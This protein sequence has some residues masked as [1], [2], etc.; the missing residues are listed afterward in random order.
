[1][2]AAAARVRHAPLHLTDG[3]PRECMCG[4]RRMHADVLAVLRQL[5]VREV[6]VVGYSMG[7]SFAL[8]L[9]LVG[10][11]VLPALDDAPPPKCRRLVIAGHGDGLTGWGAEADEVGACAALRRAVPP[12]APSRGSLSLALPWLP[13]A[14]LRAESDDGL[15]AK[16]LGYRAFVAATKGDAAALAAVAEAWRDRGIAEEHWSGATMPTLLLVGAD[17]ADVSLDRISVALPDCRVERPPGDHLSVVA[18]PAFREALLRFLS[19]VPS[20]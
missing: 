19:E 7:C 11:G 16:Q 5:G 13:A 15:T 14:G 3:Y 4:R 2:S 18:E 12:R 20:G 9:A 10:G 6:D 1:M 17:D 8:W